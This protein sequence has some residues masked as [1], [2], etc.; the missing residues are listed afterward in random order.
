MLVELSSREFILVT[1]AKVKRTSIMK[2][3][4]LDPF[5]T[6]Q[7]GN[8]K[9]AIL[10]QLGSMLGRI[11]QMSSTELTDDESVKLE[12]VFKN[13]S[14]IQEILKAAEEKENSAPSKN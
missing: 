14:E 2:S 12:K 9:F 13:L 7:Q 3:F 1:T 10:S 11:E 4:E 8:I 5:D 6:L